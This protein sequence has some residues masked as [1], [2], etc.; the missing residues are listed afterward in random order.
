MDSLC[1]RGR[2]SNVWNNMNF[3]IQ[4]FSC[5]GIILFYFS[6]FLSCGIS[7]EA[8]KPVE[9][10]NHQPAAADSNRNNPVPKMHNFKKIHV[11]ILAWNLSCLQTIE[12]FFLKFEYDS[13]IP[14]I[15][16]CQLWENSSRSLFISLWFCLL[17]KNSNRISFKKT[18]EDRQRGTN[19]KKCRQSTAE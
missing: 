7:E 5:T 19:W 12:D 17:L 1:P 3:M 18:T 10:I 4:Q 14:K 16:V 15:F 8:I 11:A 6:S 13:K 2:I 9:W